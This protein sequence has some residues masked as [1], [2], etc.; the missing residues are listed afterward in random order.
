MQM[1]AKKVAE[2]YNKLKPPVRID[3]L[4]CFV[5]EE[6]TPGQESQYWCCEKFISGA[7]A[8]AHAFRHA[9]QPFSTLASRV[10]W[11]RRQGG[12]CFACDSVRMYACVVLK[13]VY[14]PARGGRCYFESE[15]SH[16]N[17]H[18]RILSLSFSLFLS[19]SLR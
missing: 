17:K 5:L 10:G 16:T 18:T 1:V 6:R 3:F 9:K 11:H 12:V 2:E 4:E 13:N 8:R 15:L 19:L 7:A 14:A